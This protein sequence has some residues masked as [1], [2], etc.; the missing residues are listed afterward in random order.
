MKFKEKTVLIEELNNVS[1][2]AEQK[3]I[4]LIEQLNDGL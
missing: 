4:F 3:K 2:F 1:L